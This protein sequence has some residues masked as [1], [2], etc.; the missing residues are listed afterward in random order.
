MLYTAG[1]YSKM[2]SP[3][4]KTAISCKKSDWQMPQCNESAMGESQSR[5]RT[6][7]YWCI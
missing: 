1:R 7:Y 6:L 3:Q 5:K 4:L 2:V